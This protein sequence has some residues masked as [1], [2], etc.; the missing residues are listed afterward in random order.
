[1]YCIIYTLITFYSEEKILKSA[2]KK[3]I[4][5][6]KYCKFDGETNLLT[7]AAKQQIRF[8]HNSNPQEWNYKAL[9]ECFPIS[10][11]GVKVSNNH[12]WANLYIFILPSIFLEFISYSVEY[13]ICSYS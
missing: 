2:I 7:C 9:S 12:C 6:R 11:A 3:K 8:L 13:K 1:M 5:G 4:I 10:E